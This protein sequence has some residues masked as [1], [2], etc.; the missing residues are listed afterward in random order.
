MIVLRVESHGESLGMDVLQHG[1]EAHDTGEGAIL[2][3]EGVT[4]PG[5][6]APSASSHESGDRYVAAGLHSRG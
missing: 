5:D 3:R 2:L 6:Q 1:E 4:A